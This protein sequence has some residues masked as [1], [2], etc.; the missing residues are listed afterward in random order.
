MSFIGLNFRGPTSL[1]GVQT[2]DDFILK[3]PSCEELCSMGISLCSPGFTFKQSPNNRKLTSSKCSF[4]FKEHG[5]KSVVE[6]KVTS[7]HDIDAEEVAEVATV[8]VVTPV[9]TVSRTN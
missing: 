1:K 3:N 9:E 5:L 8:E 2:E 4:L 6:E 7:E